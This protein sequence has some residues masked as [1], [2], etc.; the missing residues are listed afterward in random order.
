MPTGASRSRLR[1]RSRRTRSRGE[2]LRLRISCAAPA[3]LTSPSA[4][5]AAREKWTARK[6]PSQLVIHGSLQCQRACFCSQSFPA[7]RCPG[8]L[9]APSSLPTPETVSCMG[10]GWWPCGRGPQSRLWPGRGLTSS[11]AS[12]APG[13]PAHRG[14]LPAGQRSCCPRRGRSS[15]GRVHRR[16]LSICPEPSARSLLTRPLQLSPAQRDLWGLAVMAT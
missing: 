8:F 2:E 13:P 1:G 7:W 3:T 5:H 14:L 10:Q 9:S 4:S 6:T 11:G 12:C 16:L 15:A